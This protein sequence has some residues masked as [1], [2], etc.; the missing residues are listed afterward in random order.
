M[1][2]FPSMSSKER[3]SPRA[4]VKPVSSPTRVVSSPNSVPG[5]AVAAS[6]SKQS[7]GNRTAPSSSETPEV[8]APLPMTKDAAP[9]VQAWV[10]NDATCETDV[11]PTLNTKSASL[12]SPLGVSPTQEPEALLRGDPEFVP[13]QTIDLNSQEAP[14]ATF[15]STIGELQSCRMR[16]EKLR[17]ERRTGVPIGEVERWC[18]TIATQLAAIGN[19]L[20]VKFAACQK[21][22]SSRD[23]TIRRLHQQIQELNAAQAGQGSVGWP[24]SRTPMGG[25]DS[26]GHLP[27]D[28]SDAESNPSLLSTVRSGSLPNASPSRHYDEDKMSP[29]GSSRTRRAGGPSATDPAMQKMA[30]RRNSTDTSTFD[31]AQHAQLRREVAHLRRGHVELVGQLRARDAQVEQ[32]TAMIRELVSQRQKHFSKRQ[33]HFQGQSDAPHSLKEELLIDQS[34]P[35]AASLRLGPQST[36]DASRGGRTLRAVGNSGSGPSL[37][38]AGERRPGRRPG[39][40][41]GPRSSPDINVNTTTDLR[42][43]GGINSSG[44]GNVNGPASYRRERSMSATPY[45]PRNKLRDVVGHPTRVAVETPGARSSGRTTAMARSSAAGR[46]TSVEVNPRRMRESIPFTRRRD[47][48]H[49]QGND[50]VGY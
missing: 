5:I 15:N 36:S 24:F 29:G 19:N 44:S 47:G 48:N 38:M 13:S 50:F 20:V 42:G 6:S 8:P 46:S 9:P 22:V 1:N 45:T 2:K 18:E 26:M 37:T 39:V 35:P 43:R 16:L 23:E 31:R 3:L 11:T 32:L 4:Q 28:I 17:S 21:K 7:S 10:P 34:P 25:S 14:E 41:L 40:T 49:G 27:S 33:M 12:A 30:A